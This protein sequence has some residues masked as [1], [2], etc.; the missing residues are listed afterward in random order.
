MIKGTLKKPVY[1]FAMG[2]AEILLC[3]LIVLFELKTCS[4]KIVYKTGEIYKT[5]RSESKSI[6]Q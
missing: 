1:P 4:V 5:I 2:D 6:K 3:V